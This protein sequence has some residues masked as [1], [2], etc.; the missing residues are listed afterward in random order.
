MLK[1]V[2]R[3]WCQVVF[4]SGAILLGMGCASTGGRPSLATELQARVERRPPVVDIRR[5]IVPAW[6]RQSATW[7]RPLSIWP[8]DGEEVFA[9]GGRFITL[10]H[11]G[12]L[13]V[14]DLASHA[15]L[16]IHPP[17]HDPG[18][19]VYGRPVYGRRGAVALAISSSGKHVAV[20]HSD[21]HVCVRTTDSGKV[22]FGVQAHA[23]PIQ[24][25]AFRS[26]SEL[27]TYGYQP[28]GIPPPV[29]VLPPPG[30]RRGVPESGGD[31]RGWSVPWGKRV[32]SIHL[33]ALDRKRVA[34]SPD[35]S[36]VAASSPTALSVWTLDG[37]RQLWGRP[38]SRN[39]GALVFPSNRDLYVLRYGGWGTE[40][41][42]QVEK[43][44]ARDGRT[45]QERELP[46]FSAVAVH[47]ASGQALVKTE[48]ET[49]LAN[50]VRGSV[51]ELERH[52]EYPGDCGGRS[53]TFQR[54]SFSGDGSLLATWGE[55]DMMLW[56]TRAVEPILVR[57]ETWARGIRVSLSR[58]GTQLLT[59]L[60]R[61]PTL[62]DV[63]TARV[64]DRHCGEDFDTS[65]SAA[66]FPDDSRLLMVGYREVRAYAVPTSAWLWSQ[67]IKL[68]FGR[69]RFSPDGTRFVARWDNDEAEVGARI[70]VFDSDTGRMLWSLGTPSLN[71]DFLAFTPDG[72]YVIGSTRQHE[73][74]L[75]DAD[76]GRL[77]T[78]LST[79]HDGLRPSPDNIA[80]A[81]RRKGVL[82]F[83]QKRK[84]AEFRCQAKL[85]LLTP[86]RKRAFTTWGPRVTLRRV[87]DCEDLGAIDL[88]PLREQAASLAIDAAGR[89]LMVGTRGGR[90][91]QFE[92]DL[93]RGD[94][95]PR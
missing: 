87:T 41:K 9:P 2:S 66:L 6:A 40:G 71:E 47:S 61:A 4:V 57:G 20:G 73:V 64:L 85:S 60:T 86:D 43:I 27:V 91:L 22:V 15:L 42:S 36:R 39:V 29:Q 14:W 58:D 12:K 56:D 5:V 13:Y 52:Q 21:G 19:P 24:Y 74:A 78:A 46:R 82:V 84:L 94:P 67:K 34:L 51:D 25:L 45:E 31:L 7:G 72:R 77:V 10:T 69:V 26:A 50:L 68:Q 59:T 89:R 37:S 32:W 38:G 76:S 8:G 17:C 75:W 93:S 83:N 90:V 88:T 30:M 3:W 1:S 54:G 16:R 49:F 53:V 48:R 44:D 80:V 18:P 35:G 92:L 11:D 23:E 28:Q 65:F 33:G 95:S 62:Y 55:G 79:K 81:S 70:S 63:D